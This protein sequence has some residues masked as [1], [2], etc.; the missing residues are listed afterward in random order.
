[1][2]EQFGE[3][4]DGEEVPQKPKKKVRMD[5][6]SKAREGHPIDKDFPA[7]T[8]APIAL[9]RPYNLKLIVDRSSVEAYAQ[10]GTIA[11]TNLIY[12][13]SSNS[14]IK[15]F[16]SAAK[17]ATFSGQIWRL[18]SIWDQPPLSK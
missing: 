14:T 18:K 5:P 9:G 10:N 3:P 4:E 12:P 13:L 17:T 7:K 16:P 15:I 8:T 2:R 6:S 11:M 1:M